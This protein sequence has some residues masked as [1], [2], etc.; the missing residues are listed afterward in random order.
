MKTTTTVNR[1]PVDIEEFN[2]YMNSTDDEQK[3][4]DTIGYTVYKKD[5]NGKTDYNKA[6]D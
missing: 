6:T 4:I 3:R 2:D 5:K 1:I